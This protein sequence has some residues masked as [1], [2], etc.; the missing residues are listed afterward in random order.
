MRAGLTGKT[1]HSA[2][3][4]VVKT[5]PD[6]VNVTVEARVPIFLE[7]LESRYV[8]KTTNGNLGFND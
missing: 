6:L 5:R 2:R 7:V 3:K 8:W 4:A 1:G